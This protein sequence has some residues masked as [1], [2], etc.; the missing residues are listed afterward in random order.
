MSGDI[1]QAGTS[2]EGL[3]TKAESAGS[4][5][6]LTNNQIVTLAGGLTGLVAAGASVFSMWVQYEQAST[7]VDAMH[8]K[9]TQSSMAVEKAERAYA[10]AVAEFGP[11]SEQA[12]QALDKL[13]LA[14]SKN[15]V[16]ADRAAQAEDRFALTITNIATQA[17]PTFLGAAGSAATV[18]G[19]ITD[20]GNTGV[21]MLDKLKGAF[22]SSGTAAGGLD[23]AVGGLAGSFGGL[24]GKI[25]PIVPLLTKIGG[26]VVIL[27]AAYGTLEGSIAGVE[28]IMARMEGQTGKAHDKLKEMLDFFGAEWMPTIG[29]AGDIMKLLGQNLDA[30]D[31]AGKK[32]SDALRDN[33]D[34]TEGASGAAAEH[35]TVLQE[36]VKK[37]DELKTKIEET[38]AM[39]GSA[40]GQQALYTAG[41]SEAALKME[42]AKV[43]NEKTKA[44]IDFMTQ[45]LGS[46][47]AQLVAY[48]AGFNKGVTD[49]Q[50]FEQATA[51]LQGELEA[52]QQ[53]LESG[54]RQVAM[55]Q[56]G[57]ENFRK[58][59]T[60]MAD[61]TATAVG[62]WNAFV[63]TFSSGV[64]VIERISRGFSQGLTDI[65]DYF[66]E[67][68]TSKGHFQGFLAGAETL[69]AMMKTTMPESFKQS[70]EGIKTFVGI[71]SGAPDVIK[72]LADE[73]NAA[74]QEIID[75]LREGAE[76]EKGDLM[77]AF[78]DLESEIGFALPDQI[79]WDLQID[80]QEDKLGEQLKKSFGIMIQVAD[81]PGGMDSMRMAMVRKIDEMVPIVGN[82]FDRVR[83]A[84]L[85][86]P[87]SFGGGEQ[88][89]M[90]W[91]TNLQNELRAVGQPITF[92]AD[93]LMQMG[94]KAGD[95][96]ALA[97]QLNGGVASM[98]GVLDTA[99][100]K[101]N[102]M[103]NVLN[104]QLATGFTR[105]QT[106]VLAS[107]DSL[108]LMND[109][110]ALGQAK[111]EEFAGAMPA[112]ISTT[113][114]EI[115]KVKPKVES[116]IKTPF[117][118]LKDQV[119]TALTPLGET[120]NTY[121]V[122]PILGLPDQIGALGGQIW[123]KITEGWASLTEW[124]NTNIVEPLNGFIDLLMDHGAEIW[125]KLSA[126]WVTLVDWVTTNIVTPISGF[127]D[128]LIDHGAEIWG[129][130]SAGW[131]TLTEWVNQNIVTPISGFIDLLIDHGAEIWGKLSA[132]W[133]ALSEWVTTNIVNPVSGF[134]EGLIAR[135]AEIWAKLVE[136]WN[137]VGEWLQLN[138]ITPVNGWF[139][140]LI[141]QGANLW[142][143]LVEGWNGVGDWLQLNV[144]TPVNGWF[145]GIIAQGAGLWAQMVAGWNGVG[146]W[147]Q[148]NVITP[149]NGWIQGIIAQGAGLWAKM[150]EGFQIV[151]RR[152]MGYE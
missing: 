78:T 19:T 10:T 44:A 35:V 142:A 139:Q 27:V 65:Q 47:E 138:V 151:F 41:W 50:D 32:A 135:G 30:I 12:S 140:G 60:D 37:N 64:D 121:V 131:A 58:E 143:K 96:A 113:T 103:A 87:D 88:G 34:A 66:E 125:G 149:A 126:G 7:R 104:E 101:V 106:G 129:K 69:A 22:T 38:T 23:D 16:A 73:F 136:G 53:E 72:G 145:Q 119:T 120:L 110:F 6:S 74:G 67:I 105:A 82:S 31:P 43:A 97:N 91:L 9:L 150:I 107:R 81:V 115:D 33:K 147:L 24:I 20:K 123:Q 98:G 127:I 80:M 4:K 102:A 122:Q 26:A 55:N 42:E 76:G 59:L 71:V 133:V 118:A 117:E 14:K 29:P 54:E 108:G 144:I 92:T 11:N 25:G 128:L 85:L 116:E 52:I 90:L 95:A 132:G 61:A 89:L 28:S 86:T 15:A 114:G 77:K 2:L 109:A 36:V 46:G 68:A 70:E 79:K 8:N 5:F 45:S 94:I 62:E 84:L 48:T 3:G 57:F 39:L 93:Q 13:E 21:S 40:E 148:L 56:R 1:V 18:I 83:A 51:S 137:G 17:L 63:T 111:V 146:D 130:L 141:A 75:Q 112:A 124:V 99:Q 152:N 49:L 134:V 100:G